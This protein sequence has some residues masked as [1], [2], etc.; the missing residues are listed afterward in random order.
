MEEH[1]RKKKIKVVERVV[2]NGHQFAESRSK[3]RQTYK[4]AAGLLCPH[5]FAV[6]HA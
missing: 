1:V 4:H 2:N 5:I 3:D 6:L